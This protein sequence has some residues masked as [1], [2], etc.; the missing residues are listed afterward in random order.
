MGDS[1]SENEGSQTNVSR[2]VIRPPGHTG[3][4]QKG[5]LAFEA[6]FESANLGRVDFVSDT[7][8]D[9]Y[10]RPDTCNPRHRFFNI[11]RVIT[12]IFP[13]ILLKYFQ[14]LVLLQH[15]EHPGEPADYLQ[16]GQHQQV[17][18][19]PDERPHARGQV[20]LQ[21]SSGSDQSLNLGP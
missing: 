16:R 8:Y 14:V 10:I 13:E 4:A 21:V 6:T 20:H 7:E 2:L 18:Q 19:P 5:H 1:D 15:R 9:I 3:K 11:S 12:E 17:P